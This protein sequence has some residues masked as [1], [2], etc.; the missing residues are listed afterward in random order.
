MTVSLSS[1][2][3]PAVVKI[4][5]DCQISPRSDLKRR[6]LIGLSEDGH[7]NKNK[8]NNKQQDEYRYA[9]VPDPQNSF[10][11]RF[12]KVSVSKAHTLTL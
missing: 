2:F 7:P 6:R 11:H 10:L 3:K 8:K 1:V 5:S 9:I 4:M 12:Q